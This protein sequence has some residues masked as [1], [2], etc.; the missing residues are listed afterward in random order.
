MGVMHESM[1]SFLDAVDVGNIGDGLSGPILSESGNKFSFELF[2]C[3]QAVRRFD[4]EY[5]D[6]LSERN[7]VACGRGDAQHIGWTVSDEFDDAE[8]N[9]YIYGRQNV[10]GQREQRSTGGRHL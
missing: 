2:G 1:A 7:G 3:Q 6:F 4:T 8:R 10:L 5:H 9:R